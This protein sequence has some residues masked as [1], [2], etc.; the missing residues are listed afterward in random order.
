MGKSE[1]KRKLPYDPDTQEP[2]VR[3]SVCTGEM[4]AGLIDKRTGKFHDLMLLRDRK[5]LEAFCRS[6]GVEQVKTVY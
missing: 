5:E 6:M 3:K 2:A 1:K 4:T